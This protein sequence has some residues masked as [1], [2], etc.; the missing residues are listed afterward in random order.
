MDRRLRMILQPGLILIA[1]SSLVVLA[2]CSGLF[3]GANE[4]SGPGYLGGGPSKL[5]IAIYQPNRAFLI[6]HTSLVIHAPDGHIIYDPSGWTPD[7]EKRRVADVIY[8][9]TPE[10]EKK[11]LL[12]EEF[13]V[14]P[15]AW[16]LYLFEVELPD[17]V[18]LT[19]SVLARKRPIAPIGACV[20]GV[21]SLLHRLP[22][23]EDIQPRLL[24]GRLLRQ[25]Q[26]RNDLTYT[27]QSVPV[28]RAGWQRDGLLTVA[29][30]R[31]RLPA[32]AR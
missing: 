17:D 21:S 28:R 14:R 26:A 31:Y 12:R 29:R 2:S 15:G 24:P 1:L 7:K 10:R 25:L 32:P 19:A 20:F 23:F 8:S 3:L 30:A 27:R 13:H 22:G 6:P 18:A 16:D 11:F 5:K 4:I 9:V